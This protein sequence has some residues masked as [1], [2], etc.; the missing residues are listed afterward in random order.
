MLISSFIA[1]WNGSLNYQEQR[2][3]LDWAITNATV[4]YVYKYY[5]AFHSH[6]DS[7]Q[8]LYDIHFEQHTPRMKETPLGLNK[9][10]KI[11]KRTH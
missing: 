7:G 2:E 10:R 3:Q 8:I 6:N 1:F 11:R 9:I 4:S 5:D